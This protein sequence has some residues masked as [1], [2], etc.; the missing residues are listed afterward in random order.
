MQ[1]TDE[2]IHVDTLAENAR[3]SRCPLIMTQKRGRNFFPFPDEGNGREKIE[4]S[5]NLGCNPNQPSVS[6]NSH[7]TVVYQ[8]D[9]FKM[10]FPFHE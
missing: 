10:F 9:S 8:F 6:L 4:Y 3:N 1:F 5:P 7:L 2:S